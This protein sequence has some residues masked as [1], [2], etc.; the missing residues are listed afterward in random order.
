MTI[1]AKIIAD[2]IAKD[3]RLTTLEVVMPRFILAELNTHRVFSRSSASSRAI[4]VKKRIRMI[5]EHPFVPEAFGRNR[6]GMQAGAELEEGAG[7]LSEEAWRKSMRTAID[8]ARSM[9]ELGVHKQ[10]AN[11]LLEPFAWHT[12][13]VTA[14]E[15][16]NFF[17]LR[18]SEYAQPELRTVAQAMKAA[19]DASTP[20]RIY[21]GDWHL[22][23]FGSSGGAVEDEGVLPV[24]AVKLSVA[25][26]ARVSYL[27]HDGKRDLEADLKLYDRLASLGH[28]SPLE[29]AAQV[30]L[31]AGGS[32]VF[33][34]FSAPWLQHRKMLP[35]EA[36]FEASS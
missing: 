23:Y 13:V 32:E 30:R 12:V 19:M 4:P 10:W 26:C 24:T 1:S 8:C 22:P 33:G 31:M 27:N 9:A 16:A 11:R 5:E 15:W 36:V 20:N 18:I 7:L 3:V 29:H 21:T 2:S 34:N 14:T 35:G 6:R 28:M 17:A 25:R